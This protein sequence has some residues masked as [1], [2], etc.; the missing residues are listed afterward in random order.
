[1]NSPVPANMATLSSFDVLDREFAGFLARLAKSDSSQLA[2][3]A[4]LVSRATRSGHI[5]LDLREPIV[6]ENDLLSIPPALAAPPLDEWRSHLSETSVVGKPGEFA[7]L[8][9]DPNGRLYLQRY[10]QYETTVADGITARVNQG[11][12]LPRETPALS[13]VLDRYFP[14][15]TSPNAEPD[16]QRTAVQT[17]LTRRFVVISG[18]PG[19][20]KTYTISVFLA[21]L[22]ELRASDPPRIAL[23]APTGKAAVRLQEAVQNA[24]EKLPAPPGV[25]ER[26]PAVASTLHR[27]LGAVPGTSRFVYGSNRLLPY[28][29][30]VID[31]ASMVDLALMARLLT[32]CHPSTQLILV[33]DM[34]QLASV[35]AGALLGDICDGLRQGRT[36]ASSQISPL[37]QCIVELRKNYR[38]KDD[39]EIAGLSQAIN[40][41]DAAAALHLLKSSPTGS[42]RLG[43]VPTAT[44]LAGRL[45][46]N[47]G[48]HFENIL[49]AP[50]PAEALSRLSSFRV[51]CA[52]RRGPTGSETVNRSIEQGLME[53]GLIAAQTPFYSG[54]P[55]IILKND[56]NLRLFNGDVGI[57]FPHPARGELR[58][59]FLDPMGQLRDF[60][61]GRL[62]EHE[63][64]FAMTVHKSQGSEFQDV[65]LVLPDRDS[66]VLSRELI[67]TGATRA[68]RT[69]E[70][71]L[72]ERVFEKVLTRPTRRISGLAERLWS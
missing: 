61:L 65:L 58:A 49:G 21:A 4:A 3:A 46:E 17:A 6:L 62:P 37:A 23:T 22:L 56:Y 64:V 60:A 2:L 8:I 63:T 70:V 33:G 52:L 26:M 48:R 41:G 9:L 13:S 44:Q 16:R 24:R 25:L 1:M 10:W 34:N 54:R 19:T 29:L 71:W 66:P 14:P 11:T 15:S 35:E 43:A 5:C 40:R 31:E 20:G 57:I 42:L 67:Y 7:P 38:F 72:E 69:V 51:L 68:R 27:L 53:S 30:I 39:D 45:R 32:A 36:T 50:D 59:W 12:N 47:A 55:I 28:D 18:G